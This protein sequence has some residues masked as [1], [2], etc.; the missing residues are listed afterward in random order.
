MPPETKELRFN[1]IILEPR[2]FR[3][4]LLMI[5][6]DNSQRPSLGAVARADCWLMV[7]GLFKA[8]NCTESQDFAA[9]IFKLTPFNMD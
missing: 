4:L 9:K 5:K 3:L 1:A 6:R 2:Y 7:G 8:N